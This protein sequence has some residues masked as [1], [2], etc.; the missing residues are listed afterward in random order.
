VVSELATFYHIKPGH[1]DAMREAVKGFRKVI[2]RTDPMDPACDH[3]L[4]STITMKLSLNIVGE[5]KR[6]AIPYSAVRRGAERRWPLRV[7]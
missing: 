2:G 1:A 6:A 5:A 7:G 4:R 3:T